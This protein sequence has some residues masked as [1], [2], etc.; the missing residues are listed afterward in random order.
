MFLGECGLIGLFTLIINWRE[1]R[2]KEDD[3]V[4]E[5]SEDEDDDVPKKSVNGN[6][7]SNGK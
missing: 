7:N 6:N 1:S 3:I 2:I 4:I 5:D